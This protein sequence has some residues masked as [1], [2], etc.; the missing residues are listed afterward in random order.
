MQ[1]FFIFA[2]VYLV[3]SGL[4][5]LDIGPGALIHL[6]YL[7]IMLERVQGGGARIIVERNVLAVYHLILFAYPL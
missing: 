6:V 5:A 1:G 3:F 2:Y 4:I 7:W